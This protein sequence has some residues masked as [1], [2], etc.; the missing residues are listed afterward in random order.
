MLLR[1]LLLS[2]LLALFAGQTQAIMAG[3][4]PDTPAARIDPNTAESPWAGVGSLSIA[5]GTGGTGTFTAA[6]I[7]PDYILTAAHVVTGVAPNAITFNLNAG[8]S[9]TQQIGAVEVFIH[10]GFQ[11]FNNPDLNDDLA[12]VRLAASASSGVP[13]YSLLR[14]SLPA[15]ATMT[16]VGYGGSGNGDTGPTIGASATVKR[17]GQN[18]ADLFVDDDGGSGAHEIYYFDFD[19]PTSASN[20]MGGL[21]LGNEQETSVSGG[22][23]GSPTFVQ[24]SGGVWRLAGVNTFTFKN[25]GQTSSTFGTGGGGML[26]PAYAGWIDGVVVT[27]VPELSTHTLLLVGLGLVGF[28]VS[29]RQTTPGLQTG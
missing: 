23:S 25:T 15:G 29:R 2:A 6:L 9:L 13:I 12:I 18:N 16:F 22:D 8:G 5:G 26:V 17:T 19:G 4:S 1:P 11:G 28:A 21:T 24:D 3:A 14:D 27:A 20:L 10:P 7:A